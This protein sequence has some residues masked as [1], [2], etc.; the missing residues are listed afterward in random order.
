MSLKRDKVVDGV[1]VGFET[2]YAALAPEALQQR[3]SGRELAR[4]LYPDSLLTAEV[5]LNRQVHLAPKEIAPNGK[6]HPS[7]SLCVTRMAAAAWLEEEG[8]F[9]RT[10][11]G[12]FDTSN[13]D[14]DRS[15][16]CC[17]I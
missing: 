13:R 4:Q 12:Y 16:G 17:I 3:I 11:E 8:V 1:R 6:P 14:G 10:E 5:D 2:A 15:P 9:S 7:P